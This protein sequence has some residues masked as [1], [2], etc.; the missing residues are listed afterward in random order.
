MKNSQKT[1]RQ[2]RYWCDYL[3]QVSLGIFIVFLIIAI[4]IDL[5]YFPVR[6]KHYG[7]IREFIYRNAARALGVSDIAAGISENDHLM[8]AFCLAWGMTITIV[9]FL[10]EIRDEC[11]H[12]IRLKTLVGI[13]FKKS[14]L[15]FTGFFYIMLCPIVYFAETYR[16]YFTTLFGIVVTF[17]FFLAVPLYVLDQMRGSRIKRVLVWKSSEELRKMVFEAGSTQKEREVK[18]RHRRND[19]GRKRNDDLLDKRAE[20]YGYIQRKLEVLPITSM[21]EYVDY[22]DDADVKDLIDTL[23]EF[24]QNYNLHGMIQNS[25]YAHSILTT[26][27]KRILEKIDIST[28]YG[29]DCFGYI[30]AVFWSELYG[31]MS[32]KCDEEELRKCMLAYRVECLIPLI[33][34]ASQHASIIFD[35]VWRQSDEIQSYMIGYLFLYAEFRY[36]ECSGIFSGDFQNIIDDIQMS[37]YLLRKSS[38]LWDKKLAL[39][40][41]LSWTEFCDKESNL[42]MAEFLDFCQDMTYIK[43][44]EMER[45]RTYTMRRVVLRIGEA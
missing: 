45:V 25:I 42:V 44:N 9:L 31:T 20:K 18:T 14:T 37:R 2:K 19:R 16:L 21:I 34:D 41:W 11:W 30:I 39:E 23:L 24:F 1:H 4:G 22:E 43:K 6:F 10:L 35:L 13:S 7:V 32:Q 26:W 38:A 17:L 8:D 29:Q 5:N 12:G 27:M 3:L 15:F 28:R 33:H 40:F 36:H